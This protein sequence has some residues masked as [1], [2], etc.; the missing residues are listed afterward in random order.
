MHSK[1]FDN[2]WYIWQREHGLRIRVKDEILNPQ[3]RNRRRNML[4]EVKGLGKYIRRARAYAIGRTKDK[5][6]MWTRVK[7]EVRGRRY[8]QPLRGQRDGNTRR[9]CEGDVR[10]SSDDGST[11]SVPGSL[12]ERL[13]GLEL[14]RRTSQSGEILIEEP[15]QG[16]DRAMSDP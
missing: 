2:L 4:E 16:R 7:S 1:R 6:G 8:E 11:I 3:R 14:G 9:S 12:V 10:E 5:P 13:G 15:K